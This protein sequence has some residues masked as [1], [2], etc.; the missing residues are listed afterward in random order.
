MSRSFDKNSF[1]TMI[2]FV[3]ILL[4]WSVGI[5]YGLLGILV[6]G[7]VVTT[8]LPADLFDFNLANLENIDVQAFNVLYDIADGRFTG[9]VNVKWLVVLILVVLTSNGVFLQFIQIQLKRVM[10]NVREKNPFSEDNAN[11]LKTMGIAFLI[12]AVVLPMLNSWLLMTT[13]NLFDIYEASVNF[14]LNLQAVFMGL[15]I[16]ILAYIFNYGAYL[17]EEHDMTV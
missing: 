3:H 12:S 1:D 16:L 11:F 9:I 4:K 10:K 7:V 15:L 17:Q 13:V 8:F 5:L 2:K 14:S 6:V